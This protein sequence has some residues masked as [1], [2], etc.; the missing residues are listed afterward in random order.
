M[1]KYLYFFF[2][3]ILGTMSVALTACGNDNDEPDGGSNNTSTIIVNGK[4]YK[5]YIAINFDNLTMSDGS[6]SL[7]SKAV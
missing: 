3:A 4:S 5:G 1:K 6:Q 7:H 2:V